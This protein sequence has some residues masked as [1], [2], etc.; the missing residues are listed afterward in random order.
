MT[1]VDTN[2]I[3]DVL[4][5]DPVWMDWSAERLHA[6]RSAGLLYIN[7]VGYAELAVRMETETDLQLVLAELSLQLQRAP[8]P[9]LFLAGKAF[10]R[11]RRAGGP[12]T[13][14]LPDFFIGAHAQIAGMPLLTR[15]VRRYRSYFPHVTLIAPEK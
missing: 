12:R 14:V 13:T 5:N 2:V 7:E 3:V 10:R 9:A 1:L 8:T 15:D 4:T 6:S 11:Y